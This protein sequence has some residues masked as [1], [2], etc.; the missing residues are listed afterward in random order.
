MMKTS[1]C[2]CA[3]VQI[4]RYGI[5]GVSTDS[6]TGACTSS[7]LVPIARASDS[8]TLRCYRWCGISVLR[9]PYSQK[10]TPTPL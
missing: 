5:E 4:A 9:E 3:A 6:T 2:D 1:T 10:Y 8:G 7:F